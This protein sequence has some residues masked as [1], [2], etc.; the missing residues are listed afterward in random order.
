VTHD[1]SAEAEPRAGAAAEPEPPAA[2]RLAL[3][4][5]FFSI[6]TGLSRIAG[7]VREIV[8]AGYFGVRGPM[9]A[10]TIAFQVPNLIRSLFADAALRGQADRYRRRFSGMLKDAAKRD[11]Q[12]FMV[13]SL[14]A[15]DEGR[16]YL[17]LDAA[18][19]DKG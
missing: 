11:Q 3:S 8:A 9:S 2:G 4:T 6:A 14:L 5:A 7:L 15:S 19:P 10:F 17:L 13:G 16:T 1:A 12:G 18:A